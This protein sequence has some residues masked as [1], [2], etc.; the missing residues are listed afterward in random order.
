MDPHAIAPTDYLA[1]HK[2]G[3][4]GSAGHHTGG[5]RGGATREGLNAPL[6]GSDSDGQPDERD[7]R[8][9]WDYFSQAWNAMITSLR[10]ADLLSNA[11]REVLSF[12]R[13]QQFGLEIYM[14]LFITAGQVT[15]LL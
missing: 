1:T 8:D 13:L 5:F 7:H 11:Q 12:T 15:S 9:T 3:V 2:D 10:K 6:M 14:P 4:V